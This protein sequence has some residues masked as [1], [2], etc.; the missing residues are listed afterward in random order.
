VQDY[1]I[2]LFSDTPFFLNVM[3]KAFRYFLSL[4]VAPAVGLWSIHYIV[5]NSHQAYHT[6]RAQRL[7]ELNLKEGE[8]GI[9][10]PYY[11]NRS[12]CM[13]PR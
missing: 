6:E 10:P 1:N 5:K 13:R 7:A 3:E 8:P 2:I 9:N 12:Y 11:F 4:G